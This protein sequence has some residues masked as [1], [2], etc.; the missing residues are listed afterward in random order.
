MKNK[1]YKLY[2]LL[3]LNSLTLFSFGMEPDGGE[4][5]SKRIKLEEGARPAQKWNSESY[6]ENIDV[7]GL[8]LNQLNFLD[9]LFINF[10]WRSTLTYTRQGRP[11]KHGSEGV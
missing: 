3:L 7:E 10:F 2:F 5:H 8:R 11:N 1:F 9:G 6:S 4:P